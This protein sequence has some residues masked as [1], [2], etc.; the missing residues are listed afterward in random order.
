MS[1]QPLQMLPAEVSTGIETV[2]RPIPIARQ[3]VGVVDFF[4]RY[5]DSL[6]V[7]GIYIF[8]SA[9]LLFALF[10]IYYVI[11]ASFN[12]TQQLISTQLRLL[13]DHP[14][15]DNYQFILYKEPFLQWMFNS[16]EVCALATFFALIC[17]TT[18]AY[19]LSRFR[20]PARRFGLVMLMVLQTF[21]GLLAIFAYQDILSTLG[22]SGSPLGL[23]IIYAAGNIVIGV[24]NIKGYF[25]TIP[26]ELE[27][28]A[29]V[30]GSNSFMAFFRIILP[31]ATPAIAAS[32]LLMFIGGWNEYAIAKIILNADNSSLTIPVGLYQLQSDQYTPWGYFAAAAVLVSLPLM[33]LFLYAQR[34][35]KAGLTIGG[36]K[37]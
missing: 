28:A 1:E 13:P 9:M 22:L 15:W 33:A 27:E 20:F 21:P 11:Q 26:M 19:A 36:V 8:L 29:L 18:G 35:F 31:L 25:D 17:A 16:I 23:S 37:G 2:A 12:T 10:P 32:A 5:R 30:D 34:F 6:G 4:R 3:R 14:G 7:V 24:W